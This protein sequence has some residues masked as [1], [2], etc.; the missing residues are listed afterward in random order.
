MCA[1]LALVLQVHQRPDGLCVGHVRVRSMKL[2]ERD[3]FEAESPKAGFADLAQMLRLPVDGPSTW[4]RSLEA[5]F[6]R[7]HEIVGIWVQRLSD[8]LLAHVGAVRVGGVDEVD[9]E[10]DRATQD[11]LGF[12][13][14]GRLA[15]DAFCR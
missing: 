9:A 10:L 2:I 12:L 3:L 11:G 15:P 4:A 7:D 14:I 1:D 6:R 5:T 13:T 8:E